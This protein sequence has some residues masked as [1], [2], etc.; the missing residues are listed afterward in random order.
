MKKTLG[1]TLAGV[2]VA[3][4]IFAGMAIADPENPG[5]GFGPPNG[6]N[7]FRWMGTIDLTDEQQEKFFE[8]QKNR[9]IETESIRTEMRLKNIELMAL[10][11]DENPDLKKIDALEDDIN[12]LSEKMRDLSGNMR[13]RARGMLTD[14]Q[15][16]AY[17]YAFTN[18]GYG[19][20]RGYG[21]PMGMRGGG[22]RGR[23]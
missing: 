6:A 19:M 2:L 18:L 21:G 11:M 12:A 4:I 8:L 22:G 9:I 7:C 1:L 13:D 10:Y 15:L 5:F 14:E 20:S 16:E 23:W 17:P 3:L